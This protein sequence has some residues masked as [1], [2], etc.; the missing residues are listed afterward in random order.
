MSDPGN[1]DRTDVEVTMPNVGTI[2]YSEDNVYNASAPS[3]LQNHPGDK[4]TQTEWTIGTFDDAITWLNTHADYLDRLYHGTYQIDD[5]MKGPP[6][7]NTDT[8]WMDTG[9]GPVSSLG[10]FRWARTLA[11][12]QNQL[13]TQ[14]QQQLKKIVEE[15]RQAAHALGQVRDKYHDAEHAGSMSAAEFESSFNTNG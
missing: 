1:G 10:G 5:L 12:Q 11:K 15:L 7:S 3:L 2:G 14:T 6:H 4:G 13:L 8:Q 9:D